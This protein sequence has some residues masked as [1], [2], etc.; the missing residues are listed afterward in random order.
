M[1]RDFFFSYSSK[2]F[3]PQRKDNLHQ[4]FLDLEEKLTEFGR[5]EKAGY[6]AG[7]DNESG[8][9]WKDEL[10]WHLKACHV[11]VPLYSPNYFKSPHC[12]REWKIFYDRFQENKVAPPAD[13]VRPEVILPVLWNADLLS[14]PKEAQEI[15]DRTITNYPEIYS[16]SGLSYLMRSPQKARY[17]DFLHKFGRR[18]AQML[19]AQGL[20]KV[21]PIPKYGDIDPIFPASSKRGLTYVRYVFLAGLRDEMKPHRPN[22]DGYGIFSNRQD[23]MACLPEEAPAVGKLADAVATAAGKTCEFVEPGEKLMERLRQAKDLDNIIVI[24]VDP[25]SLVVPSV[26][27]FVS[28]VDTEPLPNSVLVV[29]WNT[30]PPGFPL[31]QPSFPV[32]ESRKEYILTVQSHAD[33]EQ[34]LKTFFRTY[35]GTMMAGEKIKSAEEGSSDAQPILKAQ[36]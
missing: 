27:K 17:Q 14:P 6:F 21:R 13:V 15:Q 3:K 16:T 9:D 11:L 2:D 4:F 1:G 36:P 28:D 22:W 32:R 19:D 25:W 34:T 31:L 18:L 5:D 10:E 29:M 20:P 33:F 26:R 7:R 24:V 23:W 8:V 30:Q 35:R 12:G